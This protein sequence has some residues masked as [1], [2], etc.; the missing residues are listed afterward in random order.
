MA[1]RWLRMC[2]RAPR[3]SMYPRIALFGTSLL[4]M[5]SLSNKCAFSDNIPSPLSNEIPSDYSVPAMFGMPLSN[6]K[7]VDTFDNS[8]PIIVLVHGMDSAKD[9]WSAV[10]QDLD[11][12]DLQVM[13]VD[14]RGH[15]ES[16]MGDEALF[17]RSQM[18]M[19][20]KLTLLRN[21]ITRPI[22]LVGHSMGG[23]VVMDYASLYPSDI[24][25]LI[26]EDMDLKARSYFLDITEQ[27]KDKLRSFKRVFDS[28][29][30]CKEALMTFGYGASRI[31][32][33]AKY[34]RIFPRTLESGQKVYLSMVN[35]HATYLGA[36]KLLNADTS[37]VWTHINEVLDD[38]VHLWV[39][40]PKSTVCD[41]DNLKIMQE[42]IYPNNFVRF[43][44]AS[45]SIHNTKR[46]LFVDLL[47][48][49]A[50]Q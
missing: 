38:R 39:A 21:G 48:K 10:I 8:K 50:R 26:V 33:W 22:I 47:C 19:D 2:T 40:D 35:P 28:F 29:A 44:G 32:D 37:D 5:S 12:Q 25:Q 16:P 49:L 24:Q 11:K 36:S 4:F 41:P 34:G 42:T 13:A 30:E 3:V 14:L 15:G 20:I 31:D 45:H 43:E 46:A 7:T 1:S 17:S 9:T 27:D 18:A 23:R 6:V